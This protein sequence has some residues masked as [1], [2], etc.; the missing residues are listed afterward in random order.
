MHDALLAE[1]PAEQAQEL[2][3][4]LDRVMRDASAIVLRG[5]ELPTDTGDL[6]GP[7]L[8]GQHFFDKRGAE[9]WSTITSLVRQ[10]EERRA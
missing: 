5:Y 10:L 8:P 2:S 6:D 7:I 1:G 9:M 3:D 4:A